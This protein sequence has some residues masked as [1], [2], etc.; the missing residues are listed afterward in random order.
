M[1]AKPDPPFPAPPEVWR[2]RPDDDRHDHRG[3]ARRP[4]GGGAEGG[5]RRRLEEE[6]EEKC[7]GGLEDKAE[8]KRAG[9]LEDKTKDIRVKGNVKTRVN[10]D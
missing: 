2:T 8:K 4:G 3:P 7:E 6:T 10:E 9:R 5:W 1:K